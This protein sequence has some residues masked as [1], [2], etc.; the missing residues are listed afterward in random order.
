[1]T[2][3]SSLTGSYTIEVIAESVF[4]EERSLKETAIFAI[5]INIQ[6]FAVCPTLKLIPDPHA[7]TQFNYTIKTAMTALK[8]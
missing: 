4:I 3:D 5:E 7:P 2:Q 1:M 6:E 8:F